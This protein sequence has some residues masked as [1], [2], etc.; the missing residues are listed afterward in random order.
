MGL[1]KK[2]ILTCACDPDRLADR[3]DTSITY[4]SVCSIRLRINNLM[5]E[6]GRVSKKELNEQTRD[7]LEKI[8]E[9]VID[10]KGFISSDSFRNKFKDSLLI[11]KRLGSLCKEIKGAIEAQRRLAHL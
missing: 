10:I 9:E 2:N 7:I 4:I 8:M 1:H 6:M 11:E 5:Y 3:I